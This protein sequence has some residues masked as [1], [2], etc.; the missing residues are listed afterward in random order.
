MRAKLCS[1]KF[2]NELTKAIEVYYT[3]API[4]IADCDVFGKASLRTGGICE[5]KVFF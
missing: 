4:G 1:C 3:L 2:T 5:Q